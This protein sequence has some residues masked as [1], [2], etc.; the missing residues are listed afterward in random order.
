VPDYLAVRDRLLKYAYRARREGLI[1]L[2]KENIEDPFLRRCIMLAVDG[3]TPEDLRSIMGLELEVQAER[4]EEIPRVFEAAGGYSP[5][6]GIIGAV[7]GLI[8]VM[9]HLDNIAEVGRGIAVAFVATIYGVAFANLFCLPA[10]AKLK[11]SI[12]QEHSLREMMLEGV[13]SMLEGTNPR[14]MEMKLNGYL[15]EHEILADRRAVAQDRDRRTLA[16]P[17]P[18]KPVQPAAT[19]ASSR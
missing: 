2:D 19:K 6:V 3:N 12:R 10:A 14:L 8:Q 15:T 11:L 18:P 4:D 16:T 17:Q 13:L 7:I 9:Q 5:T 1:W